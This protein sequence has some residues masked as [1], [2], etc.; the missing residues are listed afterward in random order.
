MCQRVVAVKNQRATSPQLSSLPPN[1][2]NKSFQQLYA[3]CLINSG[4][5]GEEFKADDVPDF[6]KADQHCFDLGL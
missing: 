6:E 3:E 5:F 1:G 2:I 4:S